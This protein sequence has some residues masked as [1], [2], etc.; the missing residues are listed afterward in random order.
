VSDKKV[1]LCSF[2]CK[3][4]PLGLSLASKGLGNKSQV[5]GNPSE[6]C[7]NNDARKAVSAPLSVLK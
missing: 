5:P 2:N 7:Q 1:L 6:V 3:T 4:G